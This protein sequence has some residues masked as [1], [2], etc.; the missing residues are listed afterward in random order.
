MMTVQAIY[1]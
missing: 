1:H